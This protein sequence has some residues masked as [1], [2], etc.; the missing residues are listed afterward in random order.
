LRQSEL[1]RKP[2]LDDNQEKVDEDKSKLIEQ[3][4]DLVLKNNELQARLES[5]VEKE[6][7]LLNEQCKQKCKAL[8]SSLLSW[9]EKYED[10]RGYF[11]YLDYIWIIFGQKFLITVVGFSR[12]VVRNLEIQAKIF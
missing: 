10:Q 7:G 5:S 2:E 9:K 11:E 6:N 12:F 4:N 8:E 3:I 1:N